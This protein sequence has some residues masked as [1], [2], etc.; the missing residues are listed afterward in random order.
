MSARPRRRAQRQANPPAAMAAVAA[1]AAVPAAPAA[2][3]GPPTPWHDFLT[4]ELGF[5]DVAAT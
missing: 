1:A 4:G 5:S 3:A 2:P